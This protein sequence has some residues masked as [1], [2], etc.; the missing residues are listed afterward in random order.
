M[1]IRERTQEN[2]HEFLVI[3]FLCFSCQHRSKQAPGSLDP[4]STIK[5]SSVI[6]FR[7]SNSMQCVGPHRQDDAEASSFAT[8]L[9]VLLQQSNHSS[10]SPSSIQYAV[11]SSDRHDDPDALTSP[12]SACCTTSIAAIVIILLHNID[13]A[14]RTSSRP[15]VSIDP[16][17]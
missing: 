5:L 8:L 6:T 11:F 12:S 17:F 10:V 15:E 7:C 1:T 13:R 9:P 2:S 16:S 3:Q 4:P 14:H